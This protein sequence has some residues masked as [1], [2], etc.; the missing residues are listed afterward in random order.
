MP[1][2]GTRRRTKARVA[3]AVGFAED[4]GAPTVSRPTSQADR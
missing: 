4:V 3:P 2:P 1:P